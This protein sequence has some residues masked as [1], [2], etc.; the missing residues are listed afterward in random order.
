M[1]RGPV[2]TSDIWYCFILGGYA[3]A[4]FTIETVFKTRFPL[5]TNSDL[6]LTS[7]SFL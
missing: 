6:I 5:K 3:L 7:T 4:V 1:E 2:L